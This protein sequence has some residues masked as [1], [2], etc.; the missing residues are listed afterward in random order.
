MRCVHKK[1]FSLIELMVM[2]F[3]MVLISSAAT[4]T[5]IKTYRNSRY[6]IQ[7]TRA[8]QDAQQSIAIMVSDLREAKFS[9]NGSYPLDD[10]GANSVVFYTDLDQDSSVERVR[11]SIEDQILYRYVTDSKVEDDDNGDPTVMYDDDDEVGEILTMFLRNTDVDI[12][13]NLF[14]YFDIHGDEIAEA[15]YNVKTNEV[16]MMRVKA[17]VNV[18][19]ET[20]PRDEVIETTVTLRN[21][22]AKFR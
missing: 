4:T 9:D 14:R 15:D 19:P 10:M 7:Y 13:E 21:L 2:L 6:T 5:M 1:G 22:A 16:V 18:D 11:Y 20:A 12:L 17:I 8:V 3:A